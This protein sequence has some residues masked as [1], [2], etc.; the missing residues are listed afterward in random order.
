MKLRAEL[1]K[2]SHEVSVKVATEVEPAVGLIHGLLCYQSCTPDG[3]HRCPESSVEYTLVTISYFHE[4]PSSVFFIKID[5]VF[6]IKA[7]I[8]GFLST[9][10]QQSQIQ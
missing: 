5:R 6:V 10:I 2:V 8:Y 3:R 7:N 4:I 9:L 1:Q